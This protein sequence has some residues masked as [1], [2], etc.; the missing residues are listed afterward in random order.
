MAISSNFYSTPDAHKSFHLPVQQHRLPSS[1]PIKAQD[2]IFPNR[3]VAGQITR[4]VFKFLFYIHLSLISILIISLTL[5]ALI[6]SSSSHTSKWHLLLPLLSSPLTAAIVG[7]TWQWITSCNPSKAIK[8]AFW[9]SPL[10][11]FSIGI[12]FVYI[13]SPLS[14]TSGVIALL[15]ALIQ[16]LYGCWV[17]PRFQY[18]T[19]ILSISIA[20]PPPARTRALGFSLVLIGIIFCS[21]IAGGIG[22]ARAIESKTKLSPLFILLILVSLGWTMQF[23]KNVLVVTVSRIKYMYFACGVEIDT[24]VA[25]HDTVK[26]LTGSVS[27]G[28]VLVPAIGLFRGFARWMSLVGGDMDEFMF[29]CVGCYMGIASAL[30][31]CGN[32]W[33]FVYVGVYN[34]GFVQASSDTWEMFNRVG[35]EQ[36]IDSDLTGSFCFLCGVTGGAISGLVSGIWTIVI[37]KSYASEVSIYA[38]LIGYFMCRLAM[39][40]PQAC[41]SAY[42]VAYAENPNPQTNNRFDSTIPTRL[43]QLQ[44]SLA[45]A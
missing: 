9:L 34:K 40:W 5:Y 45:L 10:L 36:L 39:A 13:E 41:V 11:T 21:F 30:V 25:F 19:K 6:F 31:M 32:R 7:F 26:Y 3:T 37:H 28:S 14:L 18:A 43:Q 23:L 24:R 4:S 2:S 20:F 1:N 16:S 12:M 42:Y 38:F 15:S 22:F 33:G 35:L 27:M 44:R 17:S 8:A 29:S